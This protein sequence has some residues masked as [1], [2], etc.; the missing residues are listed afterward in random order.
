M[1]KRALGNRNKLKTKKWLEKQGWECWN[2]EIG[3]T[4]FFKDKL[5]IIRTDLLGSDLI[6]MNGKDILFCQ[7]KTN[8]NDMLSGIKEFNKY[9]F[10]KFVKRW[11]LS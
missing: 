6:C 7:A 8:K 4:A 10:P 2:S 1:N 3:K 9:P 11:E 5:Y